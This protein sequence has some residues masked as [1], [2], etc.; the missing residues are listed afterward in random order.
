[1]ENTVSSDKARSLSVNSGVNAKKKQNQKLFSERNALEKD[2]KYLNI[3]RKSLKNIENTIA[4][5]EKNG[6][7][8][9]KPEKL[10]PAGMTYEPT[11]EGLKKYKSSLNWSVKS[12]S[13]MIQK[14]EKR[15]NSLA[16][17]FHFVKP[18]YQNETAVGGKR[19]KTRRVRRT[20]RNH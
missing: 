16:P 6:Y 12:T 13:N 10:Y 17:T 5:Y 4:C 7:F 19:R 9:T 1:M 3:T 8:C 14:R 2:R 11:V 20:R 15:I 18:G